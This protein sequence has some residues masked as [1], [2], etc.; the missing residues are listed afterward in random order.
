LQATFEKLTGA[1]STEEM[2]RLN[3]AVDGEKSTP[4]Q[5]AENWL[6]AKGF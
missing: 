6:K 3:Y 2:R 5:V 4:R 1:I